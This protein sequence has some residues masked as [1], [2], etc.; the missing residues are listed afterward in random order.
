MTEIQLVDRRPI[1]VRSAAWSGK[2][3]TMLIAAGLTPNQVSLASIGFGVVGGVLLLASAGASPAA[4]GCLV[5]AAV[6]I[7]LRLLCNL[8][9]GMMA[10]EGGLKTSTGPLFNEFPDR[11]TDTIFLVAAGYAARQGALAVELGLLAALLAVVTA[12]VRV[13]GSSQ[14]LKQDFCGPLAKQHRM[15]VLTVAL[16][17]GAI[18]LCVD[19]QV[20]TIAA[21]LAV[22]A[23]GAALTAARRTVRIA[24]ALEART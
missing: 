11:V 9:D 5:A 4:A 2:L 20:C 17:L 10:V 21:A 18:E 6:C 19:G 12:Y 8:L 22:I 7:Q 13:F 15:H 3:A 16:V 1:S 14:G 24:R 23:A